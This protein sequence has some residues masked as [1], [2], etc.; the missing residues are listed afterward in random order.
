[1]VVNAVTSPP[2]FKKRGHNI[3]HTFQW[4]SVKESVAIPRILSESL[5]NGGDLEEQGRTDNC[6]VNLRNQFHEREMERKVRPQGLPW[7]RS[8]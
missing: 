1:M 6:S 5:L 7:W 2:R 4:R 3:D 8:G